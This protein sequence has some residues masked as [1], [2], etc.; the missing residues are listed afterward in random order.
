MADLELGSHIIEDE[1]DGDVSEVKRERALLLL[2]G[3]SLRVVKGLVVFAGYGI[4]LEKDES[5]GLLRMGTGYTLKLKNERW[6]V[7]PYLYWEHTKL[8]EAI[9]YGLVIGYEFGK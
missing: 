6:M 4:E 2:P 9:G 1:I 7:D 3:L 8:F 5:L